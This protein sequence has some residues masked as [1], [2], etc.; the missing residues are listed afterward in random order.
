MAIKPTNPLVSSVSTQL[1]RT[2]CSDTQ[3]ATKEEIIQ[4]KQRLLSILESATEKFAKNLEDGKIEL[5]SS[6]DLERLTKLT[7][8]LSGEADSITG[9]SINQTETET[10]ATAELSMSK[11]EE[12]LTLDDPEVKAMFDKLYEGYNE[13]NNE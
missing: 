1:R 12:I 7:L 8:L 6:L 13:K 9:N 2:Y 3:V 11:I 4:K 10:S 5:T